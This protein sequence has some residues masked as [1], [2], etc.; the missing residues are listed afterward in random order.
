MKKRNKL[1]VSVISVPLLTMFFLSSMVFSHCEIPC[2]IYDDAMRLDMIAEHIQTIEKSMQEI[3]QLSEDK[4]KN[5]NQ[6][7]RWIVNK[8]NHADQLS[9]IAT[10]YFMTQRIK[11]AEKSDS[12]SY[13]EYI[14]KL[15]LLHHLMIYSMKSKQTTDL[16]NVAKLRENLSA[17]RMAYMG[18]SSAVSQHTHEH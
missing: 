4:D 14:K 6:L 13:Q 8:E 18:Q 3:H 7:V 12:R 15:T 11:P 17:F 5:Y 1:F 16:D 10:Q 2:G 9:E